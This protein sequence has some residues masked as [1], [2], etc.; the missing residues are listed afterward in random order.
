MRRTAV[1]TL[2][3]AAVLGL[4]PGPPAP[5]VGACPARDEGRDP[6]PSPRPGAERSACCRP[7]ATTA[8]R[9]SGS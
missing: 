4:L 6:T 2:G 7:S 5:A 3:T 8:S 9:P 1:M